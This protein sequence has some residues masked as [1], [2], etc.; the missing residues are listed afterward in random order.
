M[1]FGVLKRVVN[2]DQSGKGMGLVEVGRLAEAWV[3]LGCQQGRAA[4]RLRYFQVTCARA[5]INGYAVAGII[6]HHNGFP[7]VWTFLSDFDFRLPQRAANAIVCR[8]RKTPLAVC[9]CTNHTRLT[10]RRSR[11]GQQ[12][13][14]R[15]QFTAQVFGGCECLLH[16]VRTGVL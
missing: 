15:L 5:M 4:I 12:T 9:S 1:W 10:S 13:K 2:V 6:S 8:Q 14:L 3:S 16:D 7:S 11:R